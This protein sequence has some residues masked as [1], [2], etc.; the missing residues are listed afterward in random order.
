[1]SSVSIVICVRNSAEVLEKCLMSV[2][3]NSPQE[4]IV[5]DGESNDGS[6]E[7]ARQHADIF[8]SDNG[9][10]LAYAR[11]LGIQAATGEYILN[12]GPDNILPPDF[13]AAIVELSE[14]N[15]YVGTGVQ[16]R[17]ISYETIW[18]KWLDKWWQYMMGKPGQREVV[19]TPSLFKR[20]ILLREMFREQA[21]MADDTDL[22]YRL[23]QQGCLLGLVP[24]KVYD[25]PGRSW[26]Q[27]VCKFS[28]YGRSDAEFYHLWADTWS[29][30]RKLKSWLH[31]MRHT[32]RG[33]SWA[34]RNQEYSSSIFFLL[35]GYLRYR[36]WWEWQ[37][38]IQAEKG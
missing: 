5:V 36:A 6:N 3:S 12:M 9:K 4:I 18:D 29:W 35:T 25:A 22:C 37:R 17:I 38:R 24:L 26:N 16:T 10:G 23:R 7:I 27:I 8:L 2:R 20:E 1:M 19:G 15:G 13:L 21:G 11:Q 33:V 31:P 14:K 30:K 28:V 34:I 32:W